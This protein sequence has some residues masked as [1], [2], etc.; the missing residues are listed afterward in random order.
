VRERF[1]VTVVAVTR[2]DGESL[3]NP[4]PDTILRPGDR[5]RVFGLPDQLDAFVAASLA[6][7]TA[8][9]SDSERS[10]YRP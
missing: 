10:G 2:A 3:L 9:E 4:S 8:P 5:L 7:P 1:G 6:A